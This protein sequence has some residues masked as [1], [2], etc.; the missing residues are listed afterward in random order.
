MRVGLWL[1]RPQCSA[2]GAPLPDHVG[3]HT[4]S[5]FALHLSGGLT[6]QVSSGNISE[7]PMRYEAHHAP[8]SSQAMKYYL[9][10]D[11]SNIVAVHCL[12]GKLHSLVCHKLA[13]RSR[14]GL[15]AD[16]GFAAVHSQAEG[17]QEQSS[18]PF[19]CTSN[20]TTTRP[21]PFA[22]LPTR[23]LPRVRCCSL[24]PAP[25]P[26]N[27]MVVDVPWSCDGSC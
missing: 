15:S 22:T 10:E 6:R 14:A 25:P 26:L 27:G 2:L 7:T 13:R 21:K 12:A 5:F 16:I 9:D 20:S 3:T 8:H 23:D 4:S 11:P 19:C 1:P 17:G 24:A 18:A